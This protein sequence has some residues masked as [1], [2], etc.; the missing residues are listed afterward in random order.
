[1][2]S[3]LSSPIVA[4]DISI[5]DRSNSL[6]MSIDDAENFLNWKLLLIIRSI[7]NSTPRIRRVIHVTFVVPPNFPPFSS[8]RDQ[9]L[10]T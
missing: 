9:L 7:K 2:T 3:P 5:L 1:M 10:S 6:K 4:I 8:S